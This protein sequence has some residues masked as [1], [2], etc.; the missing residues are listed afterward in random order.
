MVHVLTKV[1]KPNQGSGKHKRG[2]RD[3]R[4]KIHF[5]Q[6]QNRIATNRKGEGC[7]MSYKP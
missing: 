7:N 6:Q 5:K 1:G 3:F 4:K 2:S